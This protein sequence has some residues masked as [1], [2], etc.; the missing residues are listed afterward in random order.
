MLIVAGELIVEAE[1]R[2][3]FLR[4]RE[5]VMRASRNEPGCVDYVFSADPLEPGRVVLFERW[6]SQEALDAHIAAMRARPR[7]GE[8]EV[9]TLRAEVLRYEISAVGPL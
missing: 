5:A 4:S 3:Q 8:P 2:E 6:E 7:T 1:L 9:A